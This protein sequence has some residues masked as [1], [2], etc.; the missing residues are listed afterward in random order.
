VSNTE[1]WERIAAR[2]R[3]NPPTDDVH[4]GPDG[5][6]ESQLRLLGDVRGKRVIDLGAGPGHAA[7]AMA[8]KGAVA[9]AVDDAAG[10]RARGRETA[11][12]QEVRL[13]W[14]NGDIADLA[15][16]RADSIDLAFSAM[17]FSEVDDLDRLFRQVHRVLRP[18]SVFVFSYEHPFAL[19]VGREPPTSPAASTRPLIVESYFGEDPI[20]EEREG[21]P[22]VVYQRTVSEVF[23][24]LGRAGFRVEVIVEPKPKKGDVPEMIIWRARKEGM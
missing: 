11:A 12:R 23:A 17:A 19:C 6:T 13:E 8:R 4:Y 22:I 2:A 16:L 20:L 5:P 21:E 15:F 10:Q 24:A 18:N 3:G 9:I 14:H 1:S 7:I